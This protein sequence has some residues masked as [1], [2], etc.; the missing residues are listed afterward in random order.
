MEPFVKKPI[1]IIKEDITNL[2]D[3]IASLKDS[4]KELKEIILSRDS[5]SIAEH[6]KQYEKELSEEATTSWFWS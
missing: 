6:E 1:D 5:I 2:K 3:E 4:M